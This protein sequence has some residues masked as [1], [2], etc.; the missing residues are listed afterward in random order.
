MKNSASRSSRS[1]G[2]PSPM[3]TPITIFLFLDE[4]PPE[5]RSVLTFTEDEG[6]DEALATVDEDD[7]DVDDDTE[8]SDV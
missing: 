3:T 6:D 1:S 8:T 7:T 5:D 4:R 2:T